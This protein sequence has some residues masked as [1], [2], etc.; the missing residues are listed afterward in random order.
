MT[1]DDSGI[2][3]WKTASADFFTDSQAT[4][5]CSYRRAGT[6]SVM[7]PDQCVAPK[8]SSF[9]IFRD[10][11]SMITSNL[12]ALCGTCRHAFQIE[13]KHAE[14]RRPINCLLPDWTKGV[15]FV[16]GTWIDG[17]QRLT[18]RYDS[19][20]SGCGPRWWGLTTIRGCFLC[21][22][23]HTKSSSTA[24]M[25]NNDHEGC[26]IHRQLHRKI[27]TT[28]KQKHVLS[29]SGNWVIICLE[30]LIFR[31]SLSLNAS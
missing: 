26:G 15:D 25:D 24:E 11:D 10:A 1:V 5:I 29:Y 16:R 27:T 28:H 14:T 3:A 21:G 22:T 4:P 18:I 19:Y 23:N 17:W 9:R 7:F 8:S 12:T 31:F 30:E 13:K 6:F 20:C 2:T